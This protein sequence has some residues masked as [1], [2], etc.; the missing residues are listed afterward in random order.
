MH[1]QV[2]PYSIL[3]LLPTQPE[4]LKVTDDLR[5]LS[6]SRSVVSNSLW[7]HGLY[8]P[9]NSPGHNTGVGSLSL[10]QGTLPT[11][12]QT[13]VSHITGRFFTSWTTR[14]ALRSLKRR[15][16][17]KKWS[18]TTG[19]TNPVRPSN[20][21][22]VCEAHKPCTDA[23][24]NTNRNTNAQCWGLKFPQLQRPFWFK[25]LCADLSRGPDRGFCF[26]SCSLFYTLLE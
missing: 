15:V 22:R 12:D 6:E 21:V 16:K 13:Q 25:E 10:F 3:C 9:C 23:I 8:S 24:A 11:R 18:A 19:P 1:F 5:S 17:R 4:I 2:S 26:S 14:E 7:P 20:P